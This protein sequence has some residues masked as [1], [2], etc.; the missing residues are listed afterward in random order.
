MQFR[1]VVQRISEIQSSERVGRVLFEQFVFSDYTFLF[2]SCYCFTDYYFTAPLAMDP[3]I[4]RPCI[5]QV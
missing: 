2:R 1:N 5:S 4:A 3:V